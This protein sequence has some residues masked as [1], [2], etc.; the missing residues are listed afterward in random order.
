MVVFIE[1]VAKNQ[2][3]NGFG[4]G[5]PGQLPQAAAI[6][7]PPQGLL[8]DQI[9]VV[10]RT[11]RCG[12]A[13]PILFPQQKVRLRTHQ[14]AIDDEHPGI[15]VPELDRQFTAKFRAIPDANQPGRLP[16]RR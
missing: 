10:S 6:E 14:I 11:D 16:G 4:Q 8:E 15:I 7:G 12:Q 9:Q 1:M 2:Q 5:R 3:V 13:G